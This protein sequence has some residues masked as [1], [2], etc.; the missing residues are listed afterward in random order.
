MIIERAYLWTY[1]AFNNTASGAL[2]ANT[3]KDIF[4]FEHAATAA[5]NTRIVKIEASWIAT[6]ALAGDLR[7]YVF[8]GT[9]AS[10]AGTS[11]PPV[12]RNPGDGAAEVTVKTNPTITAATQIFAHVIGSVPATASS[13]LARQV[14][15]E[16]SANSTNEDDLF[17]RAGFLDTITMAI[18]SSAAINWTP[19]LVVTLIED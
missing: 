12:G 9:A 3:R 18:Q 6:T 16:L 11:T 2:T 4:S 17:L 15:Y 14:I 8:R 7:F 19:F 5:K 10:S 1:I 13:I